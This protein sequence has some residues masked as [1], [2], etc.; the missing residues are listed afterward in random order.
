MIDL[1]SAELPLI[2]PWS[3]DSGG[4]CPGVRGSQADA[5]YRLVP[6]GRLGPTRGSPTLTRGAVGAARPMITETSQPITCFISTKSEILSDHA[7]P[8]AR[9]PLASPRTALTVTTHHSVNGIAQASGWTWRR[10]G[11]A[12]V[13]GA[14]LRVVELTGRAAPVDRRLY[15]L[16]RCVVAW[17]PVARKQP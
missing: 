9:A 10:G 3:G 15:E 12:I 11:Q 2:P 17:Y 14:P 8:W 7:A 16:F 13:D 4:G 6:G 5:W 1:A